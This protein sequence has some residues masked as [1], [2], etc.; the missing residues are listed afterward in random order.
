[1]PSPQYT[2][3]RFYSGKS[4]LTQCHT[5]GWGPR[6]RAGPAAGRALV[7]C[8]VSEATAWK[9]GLPAR[10]GTSTSQLSTCGPAQF[11]H[12]RSHVLKGEFG[13]DLAG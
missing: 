5:W 11:F 7:G 13:G 8:T 10:A 9:A 3:Q 1:M 4:V 2:S 6:A 12:C